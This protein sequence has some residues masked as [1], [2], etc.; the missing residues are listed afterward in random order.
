MSRTI[1]LVA[2][3]AALLPASAQAPSP[4]ATL[5]LSGVP[6]SAHSNAT[7]AIL[8]LQ[9]TLTLGSM[10]CVGPGPFDF[11][12]SITAA[13]ANGS[14]Y[15]DVQARPA[16]LDFTVPPGVAS[17][18]SFTQTLPASLV[19]RHTTITQPTTAM[20]TVTATLPSGAGGCTGTGPTPGAMATGNYSVQFT[21]PPGVRNGPAGPT[22]PGLELGLLAVALVAVALVLRRP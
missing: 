6:V 9:V 8:D 5:T 4:T 11:P 13:L 19:V 20:G 12:V 1:L 16:S 18:Q 21:A 22:Q 10:A 15:A 7:A 17:V 2:L 14:R 3:L